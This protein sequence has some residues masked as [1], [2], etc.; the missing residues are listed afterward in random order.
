MKAFVC[1]SRHL[2]V[3]FRAAGFAKQI[4]MQKG[5]RDLAVRVGLTHD[6]LAGK[7]FD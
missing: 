1:F 6:L 3:E 2:H 7:Q 5:N 4:A